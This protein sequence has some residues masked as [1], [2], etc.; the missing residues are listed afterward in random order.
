[1]KT[2]QSVREVS[3]AGTVGHKDYFAAFWGH[4]GVAYFHVKVFA[5]GGC[6]HYAVHCVHHL[7]RLVGDEIREDSV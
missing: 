4:E 6:A 7:V 2:I 3:G 1:M 5:A